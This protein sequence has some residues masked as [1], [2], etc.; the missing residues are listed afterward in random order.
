M[1]R[2]NITQ[3][4]NLTVAKEMYTAGYSLRFGMKATPKESYTPRPV[5]EKRIP[6]DKSKSGLETSE[7]WLVVRQF[8][9]L[10]QDCKFNPLLERPE[11]G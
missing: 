4:V 1:T 3:A 11:V 6:L 2:S 8:V 9:L 5:N 7:H 10:I